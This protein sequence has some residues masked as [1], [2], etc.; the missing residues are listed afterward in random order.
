MK[1]LKIISIV[2]TGLFLVMNLYMYLYGNYSEKEEN[3]ILIGLF[4]SLLFTISVQYYDNKKNSNNPQ[5]NT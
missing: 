4:L 2:I 1:L 5:K 3:W